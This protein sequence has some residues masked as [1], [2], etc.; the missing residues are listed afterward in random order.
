MFYTDLHIHSRYSRA[1]NKN[2]TL[3]ELADRVSV[4]TNYS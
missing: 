1:T 2:C 4:I 3:E